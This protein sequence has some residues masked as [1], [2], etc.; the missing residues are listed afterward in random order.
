MFDLCLASPADNQAILAFL[1]GMA[2][3]DSSQARLEY[4]DFFAG[5]RM[6]GSFTQVLLIKRNGE[7]VGLGTRSVANVRFNG[8]TE[9]VG[10]LGDLRLDPRHRSGLALDLG[11]RFLRELHAD[12]ACEHYLTV[13]NSD[14]RVASRILTSGR[15]R[16]PR[17][18]P[19]GKLHAYVLP[20]LA[21]AGLRDPRIGRGSEARLPGIVRR[22]NDTR[23]Q[24]ARVYSEGDF[25]SGRFPGLACS[26]F[27]TI[28][29]GA[30]VRSAMAVWDQRCF[31]QIRWTTRSWASEIL[32]RCAANPATPSTPLDFCYATFVATADDAEFL[33]LVGEGRR[34]TVRRGALGLI[35]GMHEMDPRCGLLRRMSSATSTLGLY[36]VSFEKA[37]IIRSDV[38]Y[39]D[40]A[41]I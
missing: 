16:L 26:D 12:G 37:P 6:Y 39:V 21:G 11:F 1:N 2:P 10:Y 28:D 25:L 7:I 8:R 30:R 31:R 41:L 38:P 13:I 18:T 32:A 36:L 3:C 34:E 29:D 17:Y 20:S 35:V 24:F 4:Q 9:R 5:I 40:V 27:L 23:H 33:A 15:A 19:C 14:N 22:I